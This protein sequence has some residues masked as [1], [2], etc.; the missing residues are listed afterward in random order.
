MLFVASCVL[1]SAA[2][3]FV[4]GMAVFRK[5]WNDEVNAHLQVY[6]G[7]LLSRNVEPQLR[8]FLKERLYC[9]TARIERGAIQSND[10]D[11][12]PV[13][14]SVLGSAY[15]CADG[16]WRGRT[17][18]LAVEKHSPTKPVWPYKKQ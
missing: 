8:E 2:G 17:Y 5:A 12:G 10:I 9:L 14:Y 11:F 1:G 13:D 16:T 18:Q 3:Y 6:R 7:N 4:G 15:A